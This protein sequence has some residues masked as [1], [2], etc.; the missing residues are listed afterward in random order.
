MHPYYKKKGT[1][2]EKRGE[3][4]FEIDRLRNRKNIS[5]KL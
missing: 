4:L 3:R 1:K 2:A 5:K